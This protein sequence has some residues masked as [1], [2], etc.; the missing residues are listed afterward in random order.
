MAARIA[1][2]FPIPPTSVTFGG[3]QNSLTIGRRGKSGATLR[4]T[5]SAEGGGWTARVSLVIAF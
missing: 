1:N 3:S 5:D 2:A 4:I